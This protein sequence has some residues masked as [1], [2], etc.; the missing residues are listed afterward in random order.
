M[1]TTSELANLSCAEASKLLQ[2]SG[3]DTLVLRLVLIILK[4]SMSETSARSLKVRI[5]SG[6]HA[7]RVSGRQLSSVSR[8]TRRPKSSNATGE[9]ASGSTEITPP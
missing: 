7:I 9:A 4:W 3:W 1:N 8:R 5:S 2:L 6:K